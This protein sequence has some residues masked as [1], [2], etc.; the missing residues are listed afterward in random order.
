MNFSWGYVVEIA[1]NML[2]ASVTTLEVTAL[3]MALAGVLGLL[4][5]LARRSTIRLV[6]WPAIG[7]VELVRSVPVLIQIYY[8]FFVLPLAGIALDSFTVGVVALGSYY[9]SY[10]SEVFR[11]GFAAVPRDQ[12]EA[13]AA[14][15]MSPYRAMRTVILPQAIPAALPG[16]GNYLIEMFKATPLLA[17]IGLHELLGEGEQLAADTFRYSEVFLLIAVIFLALSYPSSLAVRWLEHK[18]TFGDRARNNDVW[19]GPAL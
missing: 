15:N 8:V 18:A 7:Y 17:A 4:L 6:S 9:A 12:W 5:A 3:S 11:A 1:P 2:R 19:G 16:L 10:T 13:A 14:L